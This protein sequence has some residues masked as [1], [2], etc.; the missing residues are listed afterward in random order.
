MCKIVKLADLAQ[1]F[2]HLCPNRHYVYGQ[3]I[4]DERLYKSSLQRMKRE[5]DLHELHVYHTLT[6][7]SIQRVERLCNL[8]QAETGDE[9][10]Y[11]LASKELQAIR[12]V[13]V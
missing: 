2:L 9:F 8:C 11:M 13:F 7:Q 1:T 12:K 5:S 4:N 6:R 3:Y 10:H